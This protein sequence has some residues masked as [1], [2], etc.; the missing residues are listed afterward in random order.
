[1]RGR[2][3]DGAG[4]R[5]PRPTP[6]WCGRWRRLD[7]FREP[8]DATAWSRLHARQAFVYGIAAG[9]AYLV[10][11]ALPLLIVSLVPDVS[12]LAV[13][14]IYGLGILADLAGA[15]VLLGLSLGYRARAAARR[16]VRDPGRDAA[17][18]PALPARALRGSARARRKAVRR[19]GASP[20]GKAGD[21]D[22]PMRWFESSRPSIRSTRG[23]RNRTAER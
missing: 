1:M 14:W 23:H 2:P 18:R 7:L 13:V 15:I 10:L 8:P 21:F 16:A 22:S 6:T 4:L 3:A 12:T 9:L 19:D 11:L 20:S 17:R 5:Q